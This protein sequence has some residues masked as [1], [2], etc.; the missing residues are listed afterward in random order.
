M[1]IEE[2]K[3][4]KPIEGVIKPRQVYWDRVLQQILGK[5]MT[6]KEII[7]IA[8]DNLTPE[9]KASNA[10]IDYTRV[11]SFLKRQARRFHVERRR[12][13]EGIVYWLVEKK[14]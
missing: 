12:S 4:L 9:G 14:A 7:K 3:K 8:E 2:F 1:D 11:T 13:P 5:P 10:R 6:V